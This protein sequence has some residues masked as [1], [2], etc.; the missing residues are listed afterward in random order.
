[1]SEKDTEQKSE[2]AS[3]ILYVGLGLPK[4]NGQFFAVTAV[5]R[6][7]V[8]M[9]LEAGALTPEQVAEIFNRADSRIAEAQATASDPGSEEGRQ[10]VA[11]F[12]EAAND[13]AQTLRRKILTEQG[14]KP[15]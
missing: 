5:L 12:Y 6:Q 3:G 2:D 11:Q 14:G 1:M 13:T 8:G 4:V 10:A 9:L 7:T 15:D